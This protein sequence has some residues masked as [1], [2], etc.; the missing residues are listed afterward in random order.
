M[1]F[2]SEIALQLSYYAVYYGAKGMFHTTS[3]L[4]S[5]SIDVVTRPAKGF[6]QMKVRFF[7]STARSDIEEEP[8]VVIMTNSTALLDVQR[9]IHEDYILDKK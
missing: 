6:Q 2:C 8:Y 9:Y 3:Y 1:Y 4:V 5:K 7:P